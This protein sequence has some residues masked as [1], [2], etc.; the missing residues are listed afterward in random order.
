MT[1]VLCFLPTTSGG[2]QTAVP[3]FQVR[4]CA[5]VLGHRTGEANLGPALSPAAWPHSPR[6]AG[7]PR[8]FPVPVHTRPPCP[9]PVSTSRKV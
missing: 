5:E 6:P 2:E 7:V 3:T 4:R 9:L 8:S 1:A